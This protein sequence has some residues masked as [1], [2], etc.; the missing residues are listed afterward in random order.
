M[1]H[2]ITREELHGLVWKQPVHRLA[3]Q[4]G[5][6]D[7]ALQKACAKADVPTPPRG[8]WARRDA[9]QEVAMTPLP[10]RGFGRPNEI[11]IGGTREQR[12]WGHRAEYPI[13]GEPPPG[14][15]FDEGFDA[16]RMR[17]A[18]TKVAVRRSKTLDG[19]H[20]D[21]ARLMAKD[22][23]RRQSY[24][25]PSYPGAY[26][27]PRYASP[28]E[29]RRLQ[30]IDGLLRVAQDLGYSTWLHD[31]PDPYRPEEGRRAVIGFDGVHVVFRVEPTEKPKRGAE[32]PRSGGLRLTIEG[33]GWLWDFPRAWQDDEAGRLETKLREAFESLLL[34]LEDEYRQGRVRSH[35]WS[36]ERREQ[37]IREREEQR[38][39]EAARR[40]QQR[41]AEKR[42]RERH[43]LRMAADHDRARAIRTFI[44]S[45]T[46]GF[47]GGEQAEAVA[48]WTD[49]ANRVADEL[50]PLIKLLPQMLNGGPDRSNQS[51]R[52]QSLGTSPDPTSPSIVRRP[53]TDSAYDKALLT[54]PEAGEIASLVEQLDESAA[55]T[56]LIDL[57]GDHDA[58]R[59]RL[60]RLRLADQP[61]RLPA[62]FRQKPTDSQQSGGYLNRLQISDLAEELERWLR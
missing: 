13:D 55:K 39:A 30:L 3:K 54:E 26:D 45:V 56:L 2:V 38:R 14:P 22:E 62:A 49:W 41:L 25:S 32:P 36:L 53:S 48:K 27:K 19:C 15:T 52:D 29:Q 7:V 57:A 23:Q 31:E 12:L 24:E 44:A 51:D 59:E 4:F 1:P 42:R 47:A 60:E 6:S 33:P 21:I 61:R 50:D 20:R 8:Y 11:V 5:V 28:I 18:A 17:A 37:R 58:V 40:E 34:A 16:L 46:S 35:E 10:P 43:L 9:G